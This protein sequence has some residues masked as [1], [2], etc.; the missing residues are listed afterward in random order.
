MNATVT[1]E[2]GRVSEYPDAEVKYDSTCGTYIIDKA[3]GTRMRV[4]KSH[5]KKLKISKEEQY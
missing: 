5:V 1:Y 3:D 2:D 4:P